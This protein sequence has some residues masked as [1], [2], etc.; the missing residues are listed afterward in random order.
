MSYD[1][2]TFQ[3]KLDDT[4]DWLKN[5]FLAI[6]TG[7]ATPAMLDGVRISAYG[8]QMSIKEVATVTA[9]DAR[10]L[11]VVPW[12]KDNISA[13]ESAVRDADLG[14]GVSTDDQGVR[15]SFPE[16]TT[17]TREKYTKIV[18][19]KLEEARVSVRGER[20]SVWDD[21]QKQQKD[22]DI[23]EDEKFRL[24]DEMEKLT[25][26]GNDQLDE[27]AGHKEQEILG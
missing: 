14:L 12:E 8:S 4:H 9:E 10:T 13:V 24:K 11:R 15:V 7:R 23:S 19:Q 5:E 22:G 20:D 16:L 26:K 25:K 6:Q 27:L 21:I 3:Q 18:K 2:K 1:F 17:E